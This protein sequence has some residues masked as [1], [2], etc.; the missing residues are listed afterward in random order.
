[1]PEEVLYCG[2]TLIDAEAAQRGGVS[3][4]AVL[5]GTTGEADF[6][7]SGFP[8]ARIAPDLWDV[9]AWLGI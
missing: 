7:A 2:D 8:F 5:N 3:F 6:R 1:M 9:K 4:C